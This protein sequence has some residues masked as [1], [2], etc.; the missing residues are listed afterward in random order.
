MST[1]ICPNRKSPEW[2]NLLHSIKTVFKINED[3]KY[4]QNRV[5]SIA[6][7]L[8]NKYDGEVTEDIVMSE[9]ESIANPKLSE[10]SNTLA[11]HEEV[12]VFKQ[13]AK[14][15]GKV[16]KGVTVNFM[17]MESNKPAENID[18]VSTRTDYETKKQIETIKRVLVINTNELKANSKIVSL[19]HVLLN[20]KEVTAQSTY[21]KDI[22]LL[23]KK[24][25]EFKK[26]YEKNAGSKYSKGDRLNKLAAD[27]AVIEMLD[28][29]TAK[30]ISQP[31]G[32]LAPLRKIRNS[33]NETLQK[34]LEK[35]GVDSASEFT[36][37]SSIASFA[38]M[39]KEQ[40]GEAYFASQNSAWE[41]VFHKVNKEGVEGR[42]VSS[43]EGFAGGVIEGSGGREINVFFQ[44]ESDMLDAISD[45]PNAIAD[46]IEPSEDM[47]YYVL[48]IIAPEGYS[49][50]NKFESFQNNKQSKLVYKEGSYQKVDSEGDSYDGKKYTTASKKVGEFVED[51]ADK[52]ENFNKAFDSEV[53][54]LRNATNAQKNDEGK[55]VDEN[56]EVLPLQDKAA[57][58]SRYGA[59]RAEFLK[60]YESKTNENYSKGYSV[61][62]S[63]MK[64]FYTPMIDTDVIKSHL[65]SKIKNE[66]VLSDFSD[67]LADVI[68]KYGKSSGGKILATE[69]S[70]IDKEALIA[71][72]S[73][74]VVQETV[75]G[76]KITKMIKFKVMPDAYFTD[77]K[78]NDKYTTSLRDKLFKNPLRTVKASMSNKDE[79][80]L[81]LEANA[82]SNGTQFTIQEIEIIPILIN[83]DNK[84][85]ISSLK[86]AENIKVKHDSSSKDRVERV[87]SHVQR[88]EKLYEDN[89]VAE[90]KYDDKMNP[91]YVSRMKE[92]VR[93]LMGAFGTKKLSDI[94]LEMFNS[95]LTEE[96]NNFKGIL[97][98]YLGFTIEDIEKKGVAET[99][100]AFG[101]GVPKNE[102]ADHAGFLSKVKNTVTKLA[103]DAKGNVI[104]TFTG[105]DLVITVKSNDPELMLAADKKAVDEIMKDL[106]KELSKVPGT[107]IDKLNNFITNE[108]LL[109]KYND[110]L[111]PFSA[112]VKWHYTDTIHKAL[113]VQTLFKDFVRENKEGFKYA[114]LATMLVADAVKTGAFQINDFN[115]KLGKVAANFILDRMIGDDKMLIQYL[116][117]KKGEAAYRHINKVNELKSKLDSYKDIDFS[118]IT[119]DNGSRLVFK[120]ASDVTG[121]IEKEFL[122]YIEDLHVKFNTDH[123]VDAEQNQE[124][125]VPSKFM[126][127]LTFLKEYGGG[128]GLKR[129]RAKSLYKLLKNKPYD[130]VNVQKEINSTESFTLG[131]LKDM[132]INEQKYGLGLD[133]HN[134]M[135]QLLGDKYESTKEN[136]KRWDKQA[137]RFY[138]KT[139]VDYKGKSVIYDQKG[140]YV[141]GQRR[142]DSLVAD[143]NNMVALKEYLFSM[144]NK[145]EMDKLIP[146]ADIVT[147][148]YEG[149]KIASKY[150][151][152]IVDHDIYGKDIDIDH[153]WIRN[154]LKAIMSLTYYSRMAF[155]LKTAV[156]NRLAGVVDNT[157]NHPEMAFKMTRSWGSNLS[158]PEARAR[159]SKAM[160]VM[161]NMNIGRMATEREHGNK[162]EV[163]EYLNKIGSMPQNIAEKY[164]QGSLF[165]GV[166][167]Q[168]R[169]MEVMDNYDEKGFP[170]PGREDYIIQPEELRMIENTIRNVHGDYGKNRPPLSYYILGR[171][172]GQFVL[173]WGQAKILNHFGA[174]II[175]SNGIEQQG[176]VNRNIENLTTVS[177]R[178]FKS[179][180]YKDANPINFTKKDANA[181]R[182]L[183]IEVA[184]GALASLAYHNLKDEDKRKRRLKPVR[185]TDGQWEVYYLDEKGNEILYNKA[186]SLK[187]LT[188]K[189]SWHYM[190]VDMAKYTLGRAIGDL[191]AAYPIIDGWMIDKKGSGQQVG[192]LWDTFTASKIP[193]V[194][195]TILDMVELAQKLE[196]LVVDPMSDKIKKADYTRELGG[197]EFMNEAAKLASPKG[198][199]DIYSIYRVATNAPYEE[200]KAV[201][202][203]NKL[204][205]YFVDYF[206]K[207]WE[208]NDKDVYL[209][210]DKGVSEINPAFVDYIKTSLESGGEELMDKIS[211]EYGYD[212]GSDENFNKLSATERQ[213]Y[214]NQERRI[215]QDRIKDAE[216]RV[217][218]ADREKVNYA[219]FEDD[220]M[221]EE[222]MNKINAKDKKEE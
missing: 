75:A 47:P 160:K 43:E 90:I 60:D 193:P 132:L 64:L 200:S 92:A 180:E 101:L 113:F 45:F 13:L 221:I 130:H 219:I 54:K 122:A 186:R 88:I 59:V 65:S 105:K 149:Q 44:D 121:K 34:M 166:L 119:K 182:T 205:S 46:I 36:I 51:S 154:I 30:I 89:I 42:E 74:L 94:S 61:I 71:G 114:R 79:I 216:E 95:A 68:D 209:V 73:H 86:I 136:L 214:I 204:K 185:G 146:L 169:T 194:I 156:F 217:R 117:N 39:L 82:I 83:F 80:E 118:K 26:S 67:Q 175:D 100:S 139:K 220:D 120:K 109:L 81:G 56:G 190:L 199:V 17:A 2:A 102:V 127:S 93:S 49:A 176:F 183:A 153:A 123:S 41:S 29:Y 84:N 133:N 144:V 70:F 25:E 195:A 181:L 115:Y 24:S 148:K 106:E 173:G 210:N 192:G 19:G 99:L 197:S 191:V 63:L 202:K 206:S 208:N 125:N 129:L 178:L 55:F 174:K 222:T 128:L 91:E 20:T 147:D 10:L 52:A 179:K 6:S 187:D 150:L 9:Y 108:K 161:E 203:E 165:L 7:A 27:S 97:I 131:Q 58:A 8:W 57:L 207:E 142:L 98:D 215:E 116:N 124:I 141:S 168:L 189:E 38:N 33:M 140:T 66:E 103:K 35:Q 145:Y 151:E 158:T 23:L 164:N 14:E 211:A 22:E 111:Q 157:V 213:D 177:K 155:G 143:P 167:S 112:D 170:I 152:Q 1:I 18:Y 212:H 110:L 196:K 3:Q 137:K 11:T 50:D 138:E 21:Q 171:V 201:S 78:I 48:S 163:L 77:G 62:H 188:E 15:L 162:G 172:F 104:K 76:K 218:N 184:L 37:E 32:E 69:L 198:L 53:R 28:K 5:E 40:N 72:R 135:K 85:E 126:N 12:G 4:A 87:R 159:F 31:N 134:S 107:V 16:F 96:G